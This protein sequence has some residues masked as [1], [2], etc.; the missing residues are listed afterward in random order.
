MQ[1]VRSGSAA[2]PGNWHFQLH[3]VIVRT[4]ISTILLTLSLTVRDIVKTKELVKNDI[5][6][7]VEMVKIA[8]GI[9]VKSFIVGHF[10]IKN[11]RKNVNV[12]K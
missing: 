1:A 7:V 6:Y 8:P 10:L 9:L 11:L 4:R 12:K 5:E 3:C 2:G